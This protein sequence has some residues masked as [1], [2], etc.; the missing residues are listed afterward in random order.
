MQR[1][2]SIKLYRKYRKIKYA[3]ANSFE[4]FSEWS[5]ADSITIIIVELLFSE[6]SERRWFTVK[7]ESVNMPSFSKL[8]SAFLGLDK[9]YLLTNFKQHEWYIYLKDFNT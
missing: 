7:P 9:S 6:P 1:I 8:T 3:G 5:L 4:F 2:Y